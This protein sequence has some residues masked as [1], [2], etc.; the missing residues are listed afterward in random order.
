MKVRLWLSLCLTLGLSLASGTLV[1]AQEDGLSTLTII[2]FVGAEMTFTVDGTPYNVPGTD[3]VADGGK[4]TLTLAPGQHTYTAHIPGSDATNGDVELGAGQAQV[5]GARLERSQPAISPAGLVLEEPRDVLVLF[6]ASLAPPAQ[7]APSQL[8]PILEPLSGDQ[9]ALVLVNYIGEG[10]TI[11]I[12]GSLYAVPAGE[13]LQINLPPGE[14]SYSASAG[15]SGTNGTVQVESGAHTGLGFTREIPQQEP[16]YEVGK[17]APTPVLLK[18]SVFP[19]SLGIEA[20]PASPAVAAP[21]ANDVPASGTVEGAGLRV[22]NYIGQPLTFTIDNQAYSIEGSGA[23]VTFSL[24]P[25]DYTFTAST[26]GAA[27]NGSLR[28]TT[29]AVNL[30]SVTLD[31]ES[32][33]VKVYVN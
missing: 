27:T 4:L 1:G 20:S 9:G 24:A 23:E 30:V 18:M 13:W 28:V 8:T 17:A 16:D 14:V 29:G 32:G 22:V 12:D 33:Q 10:L 25:G 26:P 3:V 2:N 15:L 11:D 7:P 6:E 19:V 21:A 31:I 5:L